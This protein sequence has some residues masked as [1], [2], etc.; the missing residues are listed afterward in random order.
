MSKKE[1]RCSS[2]NKL[3]LKDGQI[4][5]PRCKEIT[6]VGTPC[7]YYDG[8]THRQEKSRSDMMQKM[9][10]TLPIGAREKVRL[11]NYRRAD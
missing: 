7:Q 1:I 8:C 2:C 9:Y 11:S 4:K 6:E 10:G 3:L 5:C